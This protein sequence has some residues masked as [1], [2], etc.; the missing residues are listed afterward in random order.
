[1]HIVYYSF[2]LI[3]MAIVFQWPNVEAECCGMAPRCLPRDCCGVGPCNIFCCNCDDGCKP[4][5]GRTLTNGSLIA[6][7]L[8]KSI[9]TNGNN[10]ISNEEAANYFKTNPKS[11]RSTTIS[12]DWELRKLDINNDGKV[13]PNEFDDSLK[14]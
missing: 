3:S 12:L 8:F 6:H 9:D 10:D 1:M 14:I 7:E 4:L 5:H 11:L 13:S 2:L